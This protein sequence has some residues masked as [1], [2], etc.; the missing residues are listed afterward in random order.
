M[1]EHVIDLC[2]RTGAILGTSGLAVVAAVDPISAGERMGSSSPAG[3][4]GIVSVAC[5]LG[6]IALHH[7]TEK[8]TDRLYKLI[9]RSM[10]T[11]QKSIDVMAEV[12]DAL[13]KCHS[14]GNQ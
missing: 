7:K 3:I 6:I 8:H 13:K 11:Q 5:V 9:E 1:T 12:R 4:L 2:L 10:E 14:R